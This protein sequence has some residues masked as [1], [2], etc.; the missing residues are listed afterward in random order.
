MED[1]YNFKSVLS[2]FNIDDDNVLKTITD[3]FDDVC[4]QY[5]KKHDEIEL[6][7]FVKMSCC[8]NA[9]LIENENEGFDLKKRISEIIKSIKQE[10]TDENVCVKEI[11]EDEYK[12]KPILLQLKIDDD[13]ILKELTAQFDRVCGE[14]MTNHDEIKKSTF[15]E[16]TV[17]LQKALLD[18]I[19]KGIDLKERIEEIIQSIDSKNE[20]KN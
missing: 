4:G 17:Y 19:T 6:S 15:I 16:M 2:K 14:Y 9:A 7:T 5:M 12:I 10:D 13:K 8:L 11:I 20:I 18:Q 3:H 1:E